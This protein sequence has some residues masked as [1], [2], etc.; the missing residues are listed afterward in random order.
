MDEP[1]DST[2]QAVPQADGQL[3]ETKTCSLQQFLVPQMEVKS[4]GEVSLAQG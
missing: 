3:L 2:L 1:P 4:E